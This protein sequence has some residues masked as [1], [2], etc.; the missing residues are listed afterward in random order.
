MNEQIEKVKLEEKKESDLCNS[1]ISTNKTHIDNT[2]KVGDSESSNIKK[3]IEKPVLTSYKKTN[4]D[5][6]YELR[7][8]ITLTRMH[9][10]EFPRTFVIVTELGRITDFPSWVGL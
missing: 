5:K 8:Y 6:I 4:Y 9:E 2:K 1:S 7:S 10:E 3:D